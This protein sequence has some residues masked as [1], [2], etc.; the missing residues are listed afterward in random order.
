M[1]IIEKW[2]RPLNYV[3]VILN[4]IISFSFF[5]LWISP[6][7]SDVSK[8]YSYAVLIGFE[9][10]M[11]HSGVFMAVMPVR[12][13]LLVFFPLYG[14]FALVF[15]MMVSDNIILYTYLVVVFNRLRY[16]FFN[17]N[18]SIRVKLG[19]RSVFAAVLYF[20]I[21]MFCAFASNVIPCFGLS[22]EFLERSNYSKVKLHG[23]LILD[24][25]SVAMCIGAF[26]YL[27]LAGI[28]YLIS[29]NQIKN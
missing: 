11:V 28:E 24:Q 25:P 17:V 8:I 1:T 22:N 10:I 9:F 29:R 14:L 26:Y 21:L 3:G 19:Q 16:A 4:L 7:I 27:L 2:D 13:S 12:F 6:D 20:F 5:S 23:G 18:K 15:N